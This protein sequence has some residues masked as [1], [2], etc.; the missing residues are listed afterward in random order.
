M[1]CNGSKSTQVQQLGPDGE[2][3]PRKSSASKK[4]GVLEV[5]PSTD[6]ET[7][8]NTDSNPDGVRVLKDTKM[9]SRD[10]LGSH[11]DNDLDN[12]SQDRLVS[13]ATSKFS[14]RTFDSGLESDYANVI[15]EYSH[16]NMVED[17]PSTPDLCI[18]GT[19]CESRKSSGRDKMRNQTTA[20]ILGEL[21][22]QGIISTS[23]TAPQLAPKK[24]G[25]SF[26]VMI[27]IDFDELKKPPPRLAKLKKRRKKKRAVTK[28]EVD[29]K[30][31]AAEER[32]K[33]KQSKLREKLDTMKKE[34]QVHKVSEEAEDAQ[35]KQ[36]EEKMNDSLS[37]A[38]KNREAHFQALRERLEQ[39]KKHAEK[40]RQAKLARMA[41]Q[42]EG[43]E[44][45]EGANENEEVS[46]V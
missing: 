31:A 46:A 43:G 4:K 26:D 19:K 1:G 25:T 12:K 21:K 22:S 16:P 35:K 33:A 5:K 32:R 17:R 8:D 44:A 9:G 23:N 42:K 15:T 20:E 10:S 3:I 28:E 27:A 45:E 29:A 11:L 7:M 34:A 39:K 18:S 24:G 37:Q 6:I 13:S 38:A 36:T 14:Q 2:V 41:A 40:V 30:L